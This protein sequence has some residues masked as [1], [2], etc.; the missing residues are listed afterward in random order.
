[1]LLVQK[2]TRV[3]IIDTL[4]ILIFNIILTWVDILR[5]KGQTH[6][7]AQRRIGHIFIL[8]YEFKTIMGIILSRLL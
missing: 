2:P 4:F 6:C 5:S 7:R 3:T 1:M 8:F